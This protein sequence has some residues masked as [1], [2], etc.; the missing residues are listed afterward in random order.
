MQNTAAAV[1]EASSAP[2]EDAEEAEKEEEEE[3]QCV[4]KSSANRHHGHCSKKRPLDGLYVVGGTG[5]SHGAQ[6]GNSIA[7][8]MAEA[9]QYNKM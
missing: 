7:S 1:P 2:A 8:Q 9:M 5:K 4:H 6:E 3:A